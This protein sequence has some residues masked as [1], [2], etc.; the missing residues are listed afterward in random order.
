MN[1]LRN[2]KGTKVAILSGLVAGAIGS[3][4]GTV[5]AD[6]PG[7]EI[8]RDYR[9]LQQDRNELQ[10]DRR[11]LREDLR[12]GA[13]RGEIA[14]D[15]AEVRQDRGEIRDDRRELKQDL[16]EAHR[17]WQYRGRDGH[18]HAWWDYHHWWDR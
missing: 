9:E 14:R 10:R 6:Y 16:T 17:W 13:G 8:R 12:N 5:S 3:L 7:R 4:V 18:Y 1:A 15:R 2:K 11:E